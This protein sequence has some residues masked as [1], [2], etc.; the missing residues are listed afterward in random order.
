MKASKIGKE[1]EE[2]N[3]GERE[4]EREKIER[5]FRKKMMMMKKKEENVCERERE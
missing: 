1:Y 4:R 2:K 5:N 3:G